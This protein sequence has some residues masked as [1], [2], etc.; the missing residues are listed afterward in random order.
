[1]SRQLSQQLLRFANVTL[2][3][4]NLGT[5]APGAFQLIAEHFHDAW[6]KAKA[7]Q[8]VKPQG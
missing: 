3:A 8:G 1:M 7:E 6:P 5:T 4:I 2:L